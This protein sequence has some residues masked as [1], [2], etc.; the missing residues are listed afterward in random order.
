MK[1]ENFKIGIIS[2]THDNLE[3]LRKVIFWLKKE[4][5][6]FLIHCGDVTTFETLKEISK[7]FPRKIYLSLG[8]VDRDT[9]LEKYSNFFDNVE[10]FSEYGEIEVEKKKLA[11]SHFPKIAQKLAKT[12]KYDIVFFGHLHYPSENKIGKTRLVNPG[13]L[14]GLYFKP[15]FVLFDAKNEKL[16]LKL[17]E[18]I[19]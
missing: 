15:S 4:D 12:Q 2:D 5:I 1:G 13:N 19:K 3:N 16:E 18:K 14:A 6:L 11:F 10:I 9:N 8:N 17:V 7:S